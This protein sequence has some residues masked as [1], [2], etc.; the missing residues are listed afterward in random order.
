M[1]EMRSCRGERGGGEG[2]VG[3]NEARMGLERRAENK[4]RTMSRLPRLTCMCHLC[5]VYK[6]IQNVK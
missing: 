5:H 3:K 1:K 2:A 4:A 6:N